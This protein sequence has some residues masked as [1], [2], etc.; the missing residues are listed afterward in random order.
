MEL[1][2]PAILSIPTRDEHPV[3]ADWYAP[4]IDDNSVK[5]IIVLSH[6][7][8]GHRRWGFIPL[9]AARLAANGFGALAIDFSHNGR[10]PEDG[11][12]TVG[13]AQVIAPSLFRANTIAR[14]LDDLSAVLRWIRDPQRGGKTLGLDHD[15]AI[16]LWGH[17][18]GGVVSILTALDDDSISALVTWSASAHPDHFTERQKMLWREK[19]ELAFRDLNS[20]TPLALD[21]QLLDD[22]ERHHDDYAAADRA[23]DLAIPHLIVH[24]EHD[25]TVPVKDSYRYYD[26]P[27]IRA[28]KKLLRLLTGHTYGYDD[29]FIASEA[30]ENATK[31]TVEWFETY[32]RTPSESD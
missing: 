8:K 26:T 31:A 16:G 15:M 17:S 2:E 22:I 4:L 7:F 25:P 5:Y 24:G 18:R 23:R 28:D 10:V 9:L 6:G 29:G 30:L 3:L 20:E 1:Y 14:E 19:G 11:R 27:T 13:G 12:P 32:L 21:V